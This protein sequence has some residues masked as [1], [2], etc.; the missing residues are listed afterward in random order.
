MNQPPKLE[1]KLGL[2][3]CITIVA[4]TIIGSSIFMKPAAMAGQA[5]LP[6][7]LLLTWVITGV[8]SIFGGMIMAEVGSMLPQTGGQ[9]IYF[10][11]M[12]GR[13]F[14]FLFGWAGFIVINTGAIAGIAFLFAQYAEYFFPLPRFSAAVEHSVFFTIPFIG[15]F[16]LLENIGIK[17][18]AILV[19]FFITAINARSVKGGAAIQVVFTVV[20]LLALLLLVLG[21]F[22]SGKG[23]FK[24]FYS[25][26]DNTQFSTWQLITGFF[27]AASGAL[28]AYDGWNVL[29]F[30]SGEIK[31]PQKNISRG[32]F[33]GISICIAAYLLTTQAYL[34]V[35]PVSEMKTSSLIASDAFAKA[36]GIAGGGFVAALVMVSTFG[37]ANGNILPCARITFAMG[38]EGNFFRVFGKVHPRYKTPANALWLQFAWSAVLVMT[39]SFDMLFDMFV[40][41][42]W[43]FYGFLGIGIFILRKKMKE[44]ERPYKVWGYPYVPLIFI[45]FSAFY[46]AVTIYNDVSNFISGQT[47]VINSL[48]GLALC[49]AGVP[50]YWYCKRRYKNN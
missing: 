32:L 16:Y 44:V 43:I 24:N 1:R 40:F 26:S 15:K 27:A 5:H 9:Y 6:L 45:A 2:Y 28:S 37:G 33:I 42:Q 36:F 31:Q 49:F 12:Y 22:F 35:L 10:H 29:G 19:I 38:E 13:F 21:I 48:F 18:L 50:F 47:R 20:K 23:D 8:V 7:L 34:Y 11:H 41:I 30:I 25:T 46:F 14:A 17:M 3:S 4:G 39:G